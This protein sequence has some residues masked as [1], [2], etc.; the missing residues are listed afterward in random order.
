MEEEHDE[1]SNADAD[2]D[3]GG[4]VHAQADTEW[5]SLPVLEA[6]AVV[7]GDVVVGIQ[8][9]RDPTNLDEESEVDKSRVMDQLC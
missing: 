3:A 4:R 7:L 8:G 9:I 2:A 1:L 5:E 6:A